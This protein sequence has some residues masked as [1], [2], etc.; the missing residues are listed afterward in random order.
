MGQPEKEEQLMATR[1]TVRPMT[2]GQRGDLIATMTGAIPSLTFDEAQSIIGEKGPFVVGIRGVFERRRR[3]IAIAMIPHYADGKV[4]EMTLD[5]DAAENQPIEMVRRD[6]YD[7]PSRWKHVGTRVLGTQ[8]RKFVWVSVGYQPNLDAV[9]AA[10]LKAAGK[11]DLNGRIPEGQW[12]EVI[13]QMLEPDGQYHR[14]I[15]DPSWE[16]PDGGI[17]FPCVSSGGNSRFYWAVLGCSGGWR[18]LV[19]VESK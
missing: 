15:V 14:G 8:T 17:L 4:F 13:K 16:D 12:R 11:L 2:D 10:C 3:K 6:G 1:E 5:G 19:E 7:N 9:R 18:W